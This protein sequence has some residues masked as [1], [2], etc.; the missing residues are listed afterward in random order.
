MTEPKYIP[1][2]KKFPRK[3]DLQAQQADKE[4]RKKRRAWRALRKNKSPVQLSFWAK[5]GIF[6]SGFGA[7]L[8]VRGAMHPMPEWL[9]GVSP[10]KLHPDMLLKYRRLPEPDVL[11]EDFERLEPV[12]TLYFRGLAFGH[13]LVFFVFAFIFCPLVVWVAG[14]LFLDFAGF[15]LNKWLVFTGVR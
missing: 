10:R 1:V 9:R 15:L 13:W 7:G 2:E 5:F 14:S 6:W 12:Y 8:Y 3:L 4:V 11:K